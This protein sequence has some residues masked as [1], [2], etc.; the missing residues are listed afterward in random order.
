MYLFMD[1]NLRNIRPQ[2][3]I[4][5]LKFTE[6]EIKASVTKR[7]PKAIFEVTDNTE[8]ESYYR[9]FNKIIVKSI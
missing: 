3:L 1:E 9:Q 2:T 5:S 4:L 8:W 7:F 6:D